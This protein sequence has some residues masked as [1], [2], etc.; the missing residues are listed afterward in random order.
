MYE[1]EPNVEDDEV[2]AVAFGAQLQAT[3]RIRV[4]NK[5]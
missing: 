5:K 4:K 1:D 3:K 2:V